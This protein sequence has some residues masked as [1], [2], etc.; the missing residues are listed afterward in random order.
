MM[1]VVVVLVQRQENMIKWNCENQLQ[2][3]IVDEVSVNPGEF[4]PQTLRSY[5]TL[6]FSDSPNLQPNPSSSPNISLTI[7]SLTTII[8]HQPQLTP[9]CLWPQ[10]TFAIFGTSVIST[11]PPS[12]PCCHLSVSSSRWAPITIP[13]PPLPGAGPT[14]WPILLE[15]LSTTKLNGALA[16]PKL[17]INVSFNLSQWAIFALLFCFITIIFIRWLFFLFHFFFLA[18]FFLRNIA[19]LSFCNT[20]FMF[21]S[22]SFLPP[23]FPVTFIR[24]FFLLSFFLAVIY[25]TFHYFSFSFF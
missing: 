5:H 20:L 25:F 15:V 12:P 22:N 23:A 8:G 9:S 10:A 16:N 14:T 11:F 4:W 18:H 21:C 1:L 6:F 7:S 13:L 19:F 24:F 2:W 17:T 3:T